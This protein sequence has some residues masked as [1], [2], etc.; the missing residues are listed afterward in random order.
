MVAGWE[1]ESFLFWS[2]HSHPVG[3]IPLC[4]PS[5]QSCIHSVLYTSTQVL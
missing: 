5:L 3:N 4:A 2:K 1:G